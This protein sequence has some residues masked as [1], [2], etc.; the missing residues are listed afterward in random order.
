MHLGLEKM[1]KKLNDV[2]IFTKVEKVKRGHYKVTV[3]PLFENAKETDEHEITDAAM[4]NIEEVIYNRPEYWLWS[5]KRWKH[6]DNR[7]LS[8]P[9]F[10]G[11]FNADV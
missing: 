7:E 1:A 6:V 4:K 2:V 5:H 9:P 8:M 11:D 3:V 10:N